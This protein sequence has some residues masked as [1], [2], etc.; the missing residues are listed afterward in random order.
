M[1]SFN[2]RDLRCEL[3]KSLFDDEFY[4]KSKKYKLLEYEEPEHSNYLVLESFTHTFNKTIHILE[5]PDGMMESFIVGRSSSVSVRI[6]DISV[7]R[8]HALISFDSN[9]FYLKD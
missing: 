1:R 9:N 7:S 5:I 4:Y 3:C 2:W 6:T 8:K